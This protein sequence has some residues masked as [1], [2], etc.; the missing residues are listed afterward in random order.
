MLASM[1]D[2]TGSRA[3][4]KKALGEMIGHGQEKLGRG[5]MFHDLKAY[6]EG[7][8][9]GVQR[10]FEFAGGEVVDSLEDPEVTH[11]IVGEGNGRVDEIRNLCARRS[12]MPRIVTPAW[13][14]ACWKEGDWLDEE[15]YAP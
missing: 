14:E 7:E 9:A 13:V 5:M 6:F 10:T 8:Y 4:A 3:K 2:D 1:S 11:V 12:K 15:G